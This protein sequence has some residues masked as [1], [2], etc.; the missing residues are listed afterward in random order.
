VGSRKSLLTIDQENMKT[1]AANQMMGF[2]LE[3]QSLS[4]RTDIPRPNP[5]SGEALIRIRLA[6]ICATDL[7]MIKGYY[8]FTGVLGH[9]FVGQV[10]RAPGAPDWEGQRV[11]GEINI[12]CGTCPACQR[13]DGSHCSHRQSLGIKHWPGVFAEYAQLPI[14]NL[15]PVP[16]NLPDDLAVFAEP[17]AAAVEILTQVDVTSEMRVLLIGAGRLGL[18]IAQTLAQTGCQLTVVIRH[19]HQ[20]Q[21][22]QAWQIET[23]REAKITTN[24]MDIVVEATGSPSGFALATQ[25]V[26]PRGTIILKSTYAGNIE[27]DFSALVV[28]EITVI[29]SR[30]GPFPP[31]LELL[32]TGQVDPSLLISAKYPLRAGLQ[33]IKHAARPGVLK[34]LL[35]SED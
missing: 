4:L 11:V 19:E 30:C 13:G 26:R 35:E 31:A 12:S 2:W 21:I 1:G 3:N 16:D 24:Q 23:V 22:L 33:A 29:G 10:V 28:D 9:E 25:A 18:L 32:Q 7:E 6:G 34:V 8:P 20:R 5:E 27:V 14:R 15:H 17:L